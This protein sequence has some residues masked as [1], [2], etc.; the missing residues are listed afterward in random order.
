MNLV[1]LTN[2]VNLDVDDTFSIQDIS[3]WFN[4][5]ISNYNLISP[6][7]KYPIIQYGVSE[8]TENGI[9]SDQSVYPLSDTFILG[10]LLP[11]I[12]SAIRGA[13][14]SI[15]EKQFYLQEF[16]ANAGAFKHSVDIP[17][18]YMLNAKNEDLSVYELGEGVY[19]T[20]FTRSP[21]AGAWSG[22][23]VYSEII[24]EEEE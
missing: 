15:G 1:T 11:F 13:E 2:Y 9:Y 18:E 3:L 23:S 12:N 8:D 14:S 19:L 22:G 16:I 7:T 6:L 20:D 5:G 21:F 17:F 4:K 24:V 10:V